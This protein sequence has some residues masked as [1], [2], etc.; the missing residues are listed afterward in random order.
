MASDYTY[1]RSGMSPTSQAYST[2]SPT[3]ESTEFSRRTPSEYSYTSD[4]RR[5]ASEDDA[6]S[7]RQM[8]R[9]VVSPAPSDDQEE[10]TDANS[11]DEVEETLRNLDDELDETEQALT[12]WSG[13]SGPPASYTSYSPSYTTG[14]TGTG[15][16]TTGS[17]TG[18]TGSQTGYSGSQTGYSGSQSYGSP[19]YFSGSSLPSPSLAQTQTQTAT[20]APRSYAD[21]RVRLSRITE[22]TEES[23]PTSGAFSVRQAEAARR[24][25]FLGATTPRTGSPAHSRSSTDPGARELPPPGRAN[26]LIA[27]FETQSPG[28]VRTTS[29]PGGPRALSPFTT[30]SQSGYGSTYGYGSSYGYGSRPSSPT[31]SATSYGRSALSTQLPTRPSS[32]ADTRTWTQT[33][34]ERSASPDYMTQTGTFTNT[35]SNTLTPMQTATDTGTTITPSNTTLRRPQASPRS[36]LASVRNIVALWKDR[37]QNKPG[38][39]EEKAGTSPGAQEEGLFGM[40]RRV[41]GGRPDVN[42]DL[43]PT[44]D[45][46]SI[47]SAH[48]GVLPPGFDAAELAPFTSSNEP[49]LHIGS[50]WYLNV[51]S[52]PPY[53]WQRCQALLYPHMLLLSWIAPGGGRGIVGLDLQNCTDVSSAPSPSHPAARED[54]GTIAARLQSAERDGQPLMEMLVPFHMMYADGVERLAAESLL[55]RQKWVNRLWEAVNTPVANP[56]S[57]ITR[58]PTGSLRTI[59]SYN[60]YDSQSSVTSNGSRST[61]FIPPLSTLHDISEPTETFTQLSGSSGSSRRSSLVSSHHARTVDDTV[62]SNDGYV[63]PGDPRV[64]P[65]RRRSLLRR[66]GSMT[67]LDEE[68]TNATSRPRDSARFASPVTISSGPS[69]GREVFVTPPPSTRMSDKTSSRGSASEAADETFFSQGASSDEN[70]SALSSFYTRSSYGTGTFTG[71]TTSGT[72]RTESNSLLGDSHD[73]TSSSYSGTSPSLVRSREVRRRGGRSTTTFSS[74]YASG[75]G[76]EEMSDKENSSGVGSYTAGSMSYTYGSGSYTQDSTDSQTQTEVSGSGSGSGSGSAP[77]TGSY[78]STGYN[79]CDSS[80]FSHMTLY[81]S[82]YSGSYSLSYDPS[83]SESDRMPVQPPSELSSGTESSDSERYLTASQATSF[84]TASPATDYATPESSPSTASFKS[85]PTIP[86][87]YETAAPSEQKATDFATAS[88]CPSEIEEIPSETSSEI[89]K[90]DA[91]VQVS[92]EEPESVTEEEEAPTPKPPSTK[93]PSEPSEDRE[94]SFEPESTPSEK[95][96]TQVPSIVTTSPGLPAEEAPLPSSMPSLSPSPSP[97]TTS[98]E[99]TTT[100]ELSS[101]EAPTS[102]FPATTVSSSEMSLS[103]TMPS[104]AH[105]EPR[106]RTP[107]VSSVRL[108]S[109]RAPSTVPSVPTT[110]PMASLAP[111]SAE[112]TTMPSERWGI[113]TNRSYE[114]SLLQPSPSE[115]S[116]ALQDPET[117]L[118]TSFLRPSGSEVTSAGRLSSIPETPTSVSGTVRRLPTLTAVTPS[119]AISRTPVISSSRSETLEGPETTSA[120]EPSD[121]VLSTSSSSLERTPSSVSS[122]S[123]TSQS[124]ISS[125]VLDSRSVIEEM[126]RREMEL[127]E[128]EM[129]SEPSTVPSL[130]TTPSARTAS[131]LMAATPQASVSVSITTPRGDAPSVHTIETYP[132]SES[133]SIPT[134]RSPSID[135]F[136]VIR[137]DLQRLE[138]LARE[139]GRDISG[140]VDALRTDIQTLADAVHEWKNQDRGRGIDAGPPHQTIIMPPPASHAAGSPMSNEESELQ[141]SDMGT[142]YSPTESS[143]PISSSPPS[144]PEESSLPSTPRTEHT[145]ESSSSSSSTV[146]VRA[147]P[148]DFSHLLNEIRNVI[149]GIGGDVSALWEGQ[150]STNHMLDEL[151]NR[152]RAPDNA[153]LLD[154]VAA[155]E[156]HLARLAEQQQRPRS[157]AMMPRSPPAQSQAPAPSETGTTESE[158]SDIDIDSIIRGIGGRAQTEYEDT[159]AETAETPRPAERIPRPGPTPRPIIPQNLYADRP[160]SAPEDM[161]ASPERVH[162]PWYH[163]DGHR[164]RGEGATGAPS[165]GQAA[166]GAA[167]AP[168]PQY[169]PM[170]AVVQGPWSTLME[171]LRLINS[172]N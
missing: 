52:E 99:L 102:S 50:L 28:H 104:T 126:A 55:E 3:Y 2:L 1:S 148:P 151:R 98:L 119:S 152:V 47:R 22:R 37:N 85:F 130:L 122:S 24:S 125:S 32:A 19:S 15:S 108:S 157:P 137:D 116:I 154:R 34:S 49:P 65:S 164:R 100:L 75:L 54:V 70:R 63:Y 87:E 113:E 169:M 159:A 153:Q 13:S 86:S 136:D 66:A 124:S 134:T 115:R 155:I 12:E 146:T 78:T 112:S 18:Y 20:S 92:I 42:R 14:Y 8:R 114:S 26:A 95:T 170:P 90:E 80:D 96:P 5:S 135:R 128:S 17:Q 162:Q 68:F 105:S 74:G 33:G 172:A 45:A 144:T 77:E 110:T 91:E 139:Q 158:P 64:I 29:A 11:I 111:S 60:S 36:P 142:P 25:A 141:E 56:A 10:Y 71:L 57:S 62:I 84:K 121:V 7:G 43:P 129:M 16:Y 143:L 53:R 171:I 23:R 38:A 48:S 67:D 165:G 97:L 40:R 72:S 69:L 101:S 167:P 145:V 79:V 168:A 89:L 73:G 127:E 88:V 39:A 109:P 94:L 82:S 103:P 156:G 160:S 123:Y 44:P 9:I 59:R 166:T 81:S 149:Q 133:G 163:P 30:Q 140:S 21:P 138:D 150:T 46:G 51:H 132:S 93:L 118:E 161:A 41:A 106:S 120:E 6:S 147:P 117:T 83:T 27:Q 131:P 35:L 58:S 107:T 4:S 61:V 76:S 31:K